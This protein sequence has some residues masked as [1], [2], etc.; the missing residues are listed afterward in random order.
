METEMLDRLYLELS[1]VVKAKSKRELELEAEIVCLNKVI[2]N[3]RTEVKSLRESI[4]NRD[5]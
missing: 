1:Q 3:L 2:D 4:Y 5:E